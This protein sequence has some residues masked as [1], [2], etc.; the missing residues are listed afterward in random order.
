MHG[1][2]EP[3]PGNGSR[4]NPIFQTASYVFDDAEDGAAKCSYNKA[5]YLYTRLGNPTNSVFEKRMA[6]LEG[7]V[8]A[9]ATASGHSAQV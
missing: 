3:D 2:Q 1:G 7:G 4:A 9:V 8:G 5:G 6:L